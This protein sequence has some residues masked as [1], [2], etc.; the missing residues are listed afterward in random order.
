MSAMN[1]HAGTPLAD[2]R[3]AERGR[4]RLTPVRAGVVGAVVTVGIVVRAHA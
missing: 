1:A 2:A 4:R 3:R